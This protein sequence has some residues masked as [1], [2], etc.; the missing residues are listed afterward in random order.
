MKSSY[1]LIGLLSFT[2]G[3]QFAETLA[4]LFRKRFRTNGLPLKSPHS[5]RVVACRRIEPLIGHRFAALG[6]QPIRPGGLAVQD[7]QRANLENCV[8]APNATNSLTHLFTHSFIHS[9]T[10]LLTYGNSTTSSRWQHVS[11]KSYYLRKTINTSAAQTPPT[12][13]STISNNIGLLYVS[14]IRL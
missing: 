2:D 12:T 6:H 13:H 3:G 4:H 14:L 10:R 7:D 8:R 5:C 9:L 1:I 11:L